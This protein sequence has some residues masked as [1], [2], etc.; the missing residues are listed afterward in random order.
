MTFNMENI[1]GLFQNVYLPHKALLFYRSIK[2]DGSVYVEAYDSDEKGFLINAHPLSLS[3]SEAL[4]DT[5]HDSAELKKD[6]LK[7]KGLLPENVLYINA[8][9]NGY[10]IWYT[11]AQTVP[12][13]FQEDLG[14][15]N[16]KAHVPALIW[17]A[18][19]KELSIYA[20]VDE[21]NPTEKTLLYYAPFFNIYKNGRVCMGTVDIDIDSKCC[22]E[23]FIALWESYFF[24]SKFSH[25]LDTYNPINSNIVQLWQ[26]QVSGKSKFPHDE[27]I[28][29]GKTLK[30]LIQ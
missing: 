19:K 2:E 14:V 24:N 25:L 27:L 20:I 9:K 16:G 11:Q 21:T 28:K 23:E 6:F 29:N 13:F 30:N 12:L 15:P 5:L 8:G 10:A 1:T 3:E 4:A 18:S 17:K 22:L 26:Q 7:S